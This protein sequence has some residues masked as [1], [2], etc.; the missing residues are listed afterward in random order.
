MDPDTFVVAARRLAEEQERIDRM[1]AALNAATLAALET[2][3]QAGGL[4][5]CVQELLDDERLREMARGR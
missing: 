2:Q 3:D 4:P 1:R 5:F